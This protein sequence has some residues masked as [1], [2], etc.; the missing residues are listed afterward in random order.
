M[1]I[2]REECPWC[3]TPNPLVGEPTQ[4]LN[5]AVLN[6]NVHI[7]NGYTNG[8][9]HTAVQTVGLPAI[10]DIDIPTVTI[11]HD[12]LDAQPQGRGRRF[13]VRTFGW[14]LV[15]LLV[16]V[17]GF[18]AAGVLQGLNDREVV[19]TTEA[20][21]A[22][23]RGRELVDQGQYDLAIAYFQEALRLEPNFPAAQQL[24]AVAEQELAAQQ[25]GAPVVIEETPTPADT[26][27]ADGA[28]TGATEA[29]ENKEWVVAADGFTTIQV[30]APTY[31]PDEVN[32]GLFTAYVGLGQEA[33]EDRDLDNALRYF[34]QALLVNPSA[35]DLAELRRLTSSY[36]TAM[37]AF[38]R[39][40]WS[41]AADQFRAVYVIDPDFLE[42]AENL[43]QSHLELADAFAERDI[44]CDAAQNYRAALSIEEEEAIA[45]SA[46]A[47][48][49]Q[50]SVVSTP[51]PVPPTPEITQ[52]DLPT[53]ETGATATITGTI[54]PDVRGT[55]IAIPTGTPRPAGP[56]SGFA[57]QPGV[58]TENLGN[59]CFGRYILGTVFNGDGAPVPGVTLLLVDQYG[60]RVS[61]VSK[62]NPPGAFDLPISQGSQTYQ[63][64]VVAGDEVLSPPVTIFQSE[65]ALTS[66]VAC[67]TVNWIQQ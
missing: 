10:G 59:G 7:T 21:A 27:D 62:D 63:L 49:R 13:W 30:Q 11:D 2:S 57:Y 61:A 43:K 35:S 36:R 22:Y 67:Y 33:L 8:T 6:G 15:A 19:S 38:E 58:V 50:C 45:A 37:V 51:R 34:D 31:R 4:T 56:A 46:L 9:R 29:L 55:P 20:I 26:F 18:T 39:E 14:A 52:D 1:H 60:N 47:A 12:P 54:F 41:Q 24:M 25:G 3:G 32:A 16:A 65:A 42:V 64:T 48:E 66:Q 23:E 17:M 5:G 44:W 53:P 40:N 28:F